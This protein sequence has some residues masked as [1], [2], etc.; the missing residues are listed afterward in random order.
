M[1]TLKSALAPPSLALHFPFVSPEL[2]L[3]PYLH[4]TITFFSL[5]KEKVKHV[6][7]TYMA[8][9]EM[10]S[11]WYIHGW[12]IFIQKIR[13]FLANITDFFSMDSL[14]RTL[15]QPFRQISAASAS[16]EASLDLKFQMFLDRLISRIIGFF[17]RL[18]LL[19][20][21][22]IIIVFGGIISLALIILWPLIPFAPLAGIILCITG[23]IV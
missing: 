19:L 23:V 2:D 18:L 16:A 7:I 10:L 21:G 17:S 14:V 22:T 20:I 9:T 13:A 5:S 15:F 8:I 4:Y 11:W 6:I 1:A 12:L 3:R